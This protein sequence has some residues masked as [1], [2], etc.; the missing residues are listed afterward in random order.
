MLKTRPKSITFLQCDQKLFSYSSGLEQSCI[1]KHWSVANKSSTLVFSL[2]SGR[3]DEK[4]APEADIRW[5]THNRTVSV[6]DLK[7]WT[8]V[9]VFAASSTTSV[10]THPPPPRASETKRRSATVSERGRKIERGRERGRKRGRE[11]EIVRRRKDGTVTLRNP[12][13]MTR[14]GDPS[15]S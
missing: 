12:E 14:S 2:F 10:I 13:L 3:L 15:L 8:S 5:V 11:R 1:F 6:Y 7:F 9:C 4:K